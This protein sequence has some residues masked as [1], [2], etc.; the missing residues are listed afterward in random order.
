MITLTTD[1]GLKDPYVAEMKGAIY[2]IT[3]K[4]TIVDVSHLVDKFS[5]RMGAFILTS[6]VP[7]FS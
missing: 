1:F 4:A 3:P 6:V 2:Q 7:F 5:V